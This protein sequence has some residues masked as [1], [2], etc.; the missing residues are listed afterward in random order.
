MSESEHAAR[1]V[2]RLDVVS[3]RLRELEGAG[4]RIGLTQPDV[5]GDER[6]SE[7]NVWGHIGEFGDYWTAEL[8]RVLE[9]EGTE[10]VA[11]GRTK[12]DPIR[13]SRVAEARLEDIPAYLASALSAI[14]GLRSLLLSLSEDDFL[15]RGRHETLGEMD[16]DDILEEFLVG[17]FEEHADQLETLSLRAESEEPRR[18]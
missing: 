12:S 4:R 15:R 8:R 3:D 18:K 14:A 17:H 2:G 11:F 6:W 7:I 1:W 9:G 13:R 16:V 5:G 10:P